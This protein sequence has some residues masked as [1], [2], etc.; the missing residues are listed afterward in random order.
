MEM[1]CVANEKICFTAEMQRTQRKTH[2]DSTQ[3]RKEKTN[4]KHVIYARAENTMGPY[5]ELVPCILACIAP[6]R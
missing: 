1:A 3:R 6:L 5:R 4:K 2:K